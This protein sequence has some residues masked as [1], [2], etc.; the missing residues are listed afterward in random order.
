MEVVVYSGR[1]EEASGGEVQKH[2]GKGKQSFRT[3]GALDPLNS[4]GSFRLIIRCE[5]DMLQGCKRLAVLHGDMKCHF[6][7]VAEMEWSQWLGLVATGIQL[8]GVGG[9]V[10][11]TDSD[12]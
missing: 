4:S 9:S 7:V 5:F 8:T 2:I 12:S 10:I 3:C 1:A 11:F 6:Q